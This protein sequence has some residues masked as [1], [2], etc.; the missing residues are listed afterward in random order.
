MKTPLH[1]MRKNFFGKRKKNQ[2]TQWIHYPQNLR[3]R[4][5]KLRKGC[6]YDY[7]SISFQ[8]NSPILFIPS[9]FSFSLYARLSLSFSLVFLVVIFKSTECYYFSVNQREKNFL[10]FFRRRI[11]FKKKEKGCN[12]RDTQLVDFMNATKKLVPKV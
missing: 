12:V 10:F 5:L 2:C 8:M 6:V 4:F 1:S 9:S 11:I 3:L 7:N